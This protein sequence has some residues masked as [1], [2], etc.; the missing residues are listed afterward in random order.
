MK[1]HLSTH[2]ML[3]KILQHIEQPNKFWYRLTWGKVLGAFTIVGCLASLIFFWPRF[4]ITQSEPVDPKDV[5]SAAFVLTNT[6]WTSLHHVRIEYAIA[7]TTFDNG[8]GPIIGDPHYK[9]RLWLTSWD[10]PVVGIDQQATITVEQLFNGEH[11]ESCDMAIVVVYQP[12]VIPYDREGVFR[13]VAKR[14]TNHQLYW[15]AEPVPPPAP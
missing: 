3:E 13:F 4:T 6:G 14:Q 10:E 8:M 5:F 2:Q 15:Y 12:W 11:V 1:D 7:R 9:S